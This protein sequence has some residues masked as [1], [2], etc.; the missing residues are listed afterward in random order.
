MPLPTHITT[1]VDERRFIAQSQRTLDFAPFQSLLAVHIDKLLE[2]PGLTPEARTLLK[3]AKI[4]EETR[5]L[6]SAKR[7]KEMLTAESKVTPKNA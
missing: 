1:N 2:G 5:V 3:A 4:T 6:P 7:L